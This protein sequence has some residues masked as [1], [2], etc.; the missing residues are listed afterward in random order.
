MS[1]ALVF[2]VMAL[3]VLASLWLERRVS[4]FRKLGAAATAILM[5]LALSNTGV[6]PGASP[7]YD[8]LMGQGVIAGI[9]LVLL[10][11]NLSSL[12][13]AGRPMLV[14]FALGAAG[15]AL[16]ALAMASLLGGSVG[17]DTWKLSGQFA[18][19]YIGGGMNF[20]AVGQELGT[21]SDLF[22]AGI[23]A[24][25]I[26]TAIWLVACLVIPELM[27]RT[28]TAVA[29][30]DTARDEDS[31]A[32][33]LQSSGGAMTIFDFGGLAVVVFDRCGRRRC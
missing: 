30:D 32:A 31:P 33:L 29:D 6:I 11:V 7:V 14:A 27:P 5:A 2:F 21:R 25:V 13:R 24:D 4:A 1:P 16:G 10:G 8:F 17:A 26:V 18:S 23:A 20:A 28:T 19:T 15:S 12:S 9:V 22:S 3:V